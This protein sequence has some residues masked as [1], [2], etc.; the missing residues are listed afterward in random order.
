MGPDSRRSGEY[1]RR[2]R[3]ETGPYWGA[4]VHPHLFLD[5]PVC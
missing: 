5:W 3:M 4:M 1:T 2:Q